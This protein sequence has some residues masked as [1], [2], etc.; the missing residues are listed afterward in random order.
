MRSDMA[1]MES[2]VRTCFAK[3]RHA[4][5]TSTSAPNELKKKG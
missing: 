4:E 3:H 1:D 5:S 2:D